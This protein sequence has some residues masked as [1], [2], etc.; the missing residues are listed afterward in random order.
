MI[1]GDCLSAG[2]YAMT[3]DFIDEIYTMVYMAF[4]HGQKAVDVN[5]FPFKMD[6]AHMRAHANSR[7]YHFWQN[8]KVGYDMFERTHMPPAVSVGNKAYAF[9]LVRGQ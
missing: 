2:C 3:D 6:E 5:I 4:L 7:N 9:E 8:L 1:H